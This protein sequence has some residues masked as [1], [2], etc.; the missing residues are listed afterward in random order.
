MQRSSSCN[1]MHG[2]LTDKDTTRKIDAA[3]E[4]MEPEQ[5]EI[6]LYKKNSKYIITATVVGYEIWSVDFRTSGSGSLSFSRHFDII[7][8]AKKANNFHHCKKAERAQDSADFYD[9]A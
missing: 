2:E 9:E 7:F 1:F 3:F 6:L 4:D 8:R 5:V